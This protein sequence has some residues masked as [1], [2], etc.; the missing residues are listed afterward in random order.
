MKVSII[1]GGGLV[2]GGLVTLGHCS[3]LLVL[4]TGGTLCAPVDYNIPH[5]PD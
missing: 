5:T 3:T 2:G 1:G 4:V